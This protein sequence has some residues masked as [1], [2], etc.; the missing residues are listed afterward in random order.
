MSLRALSAAITIVCCLASAV[1]GRQ[2]VSGL[3]SAGGG[4]VLHAQVQDQPIT[5]ATVRYIRRALNE[6]HLNNAR[7]LV[8]EL[9]TPGG[10]LKSTQEIVRDI[11]ASEIPVVV[12]VSPSGGRAASAGM[13][14]TLAGHVA[15]MAPGTRI[16][17]AHP[18]QI[19]KLPFPQPESP[20]PPP[21]DTDEDISPSPESPESAPTAIEEKILN[22]TVAWARSLAELHGR[23]AEWAA[24]AVSDSRVLVASEAV[25]EGVVDLLA[26]DLSSLLS[27]L[28]GREVFVLKGQSRS[29]SVRLRTTDAVVRTVEMW[30]GERILA[31]IST[32]NIALVLLI[33]GFYGILFELYSPGWGVAGTLGAVSLVLGFFGLSVLPINYAGLVLVFLALG[34][35]VA[36]AFVTSFG[37]LTVGG[38]VCLIVGGT[39]LVDSP[40]GFLRV[41]MEVIAPIAV[42]TALI[43]IF[44]VSGVVRVHRARVQTGRENLIGLEAVARDTFQAVEGEYVGP[45]LV[46]GELWQAHSPNPVASGEHVH[47]KDL[48]GLTLH[49]ECNGQQEL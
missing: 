14:I 3:E 20:R 23:N 25:K 37:A 45:V 26:T 31:V 33:F 30:W 38:I 8:I 7:C 2:S 44:L 48:Q 42:A 41:S 15:A 28:D 13:F 6:A 36:E 40:A 10:V 21:P 46:H 19:G 1:Y 9:D 11:L 27:E 35:F 17:A 5:P 49:V 16:G 12:Y 47:I 39:M 4:I 32:P 22:D 43:S 34:M 18:V 29:Q 24:M